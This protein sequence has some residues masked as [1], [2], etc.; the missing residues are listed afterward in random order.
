LLAELVNDAGANRNALLDAQHRPSFA[1]KMLGGAEAA[2]RGAAQL[3]KLVRVEGE[4]HVLHVYS[5]L[6]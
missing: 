3:L 5:G 1:G 4:M 2:L 6:F